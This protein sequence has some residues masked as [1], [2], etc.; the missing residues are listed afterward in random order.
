[1]FAYCLNNPTILKDENGHSAILTTIGI[2]AIGGVIG[3]VVS[4]ASSIITQKALTGSVNWKSV[5]VAAV[6]GLVSGAVAASPI[7]IGGQIAIGGAL[8]GVSYIADSYV[9]QKSMYLGEAGLS[10][11]MGMASGAIGGPGANKGMVLSDT[12]EFVGKTAAREARRQNQTYAAK[13]LTR[14]T[15]YGTN[16]LS[17]TAWEASIRFSAGCGVSSGVTTAASNSGILSW[18]RFWEHG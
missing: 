1:M 5:G 7:G 10:I 17:S 16:I 6:S 3:A 12:I 13:A 8:G 15:A 2:M 18:C 14:A 4:S 11:M 9:N